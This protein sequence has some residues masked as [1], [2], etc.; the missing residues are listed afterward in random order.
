MPTAFI[1]G[2]GGIGSAVA[3]LLRV[4]LDQPVHIIFGDRSSSAIEAALQFANSK[5]DLS[6]SEPQYVCGQVM[7]AN[8]EWEQSLEA[9]DII[10]DCLPGRF[11][12]AM[13][14]LAIKYSLHYVNLTEYVAETK[15]IISLAE[16]ASTGFALQCGLAPGFVNVLGKKLYEEFCSAHGV[17][18]ASSL[19]MRVGALTRH[20]IEPH[21]YGFTW[22]PI[23][24]AT[25]YVKDAEVVRDHKMIRVPSLSGLRRICVDGLWLEE[26]LTSGGAAD[27]PQAYSQRICNIDYKTLRYPGHFQWAKD[28]IAQVPEGQ[29]VIATLERE[30]LSK[31]P[32]LEE[33]LVIVYAAIE[34]EDSAGQLR[35]IEASYRIEPMDIGGVTLRAIQSTTAA[36]MAEAAR[37]LLRGEQSG[38]LLQSQFDTESYLSGPFVSAIYGQRR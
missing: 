29:D 33:D 10:L 14:K 4:F 34:G 1:A 27:I 26:D 17:Q 31:I 37:L 8:G 19:E 2:S 13:A 36:G 28:I 32:L 24:V 25:E 30:M 22:S 15:E 23:G 3:V 9:A 11:A 18:D 5:S 16:G 12:P 38:V 7:D 6:K 21:Y 20:S 35:R